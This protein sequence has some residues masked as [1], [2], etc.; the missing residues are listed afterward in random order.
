VLRRPLF[1]FTTSAIAFVFGLMFFYFDD[2]LFFS[3]IFTFFVPLDR[4]ATFV[5]DLAISLLSGSVIVLS[6]FQLRNI[7]TTTK[8]RTRV[9]FVGIL[10]ALLAGACPCYYLVPLLA[11]AG[12]AGGIIGAVGIIMYEYQFPIKLFSLGLLIFVSLTLEAS[13]RSACEVP[14]LY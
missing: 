7:P 5:I 4:L 6:V 1:G 9:G 3:P 11:V 14:P 2:F 13:L 12:G 10:A 8:K